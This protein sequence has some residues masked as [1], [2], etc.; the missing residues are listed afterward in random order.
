MAK[1]KGWYLARIREGL[2][3]AVQ[4]KVDDRLNRQFTIG[5]RLAFLTHGS[6]DICGGQF[7]RSLLSIGSVVTQD[8]TSPHVAGLNGTWVRFGPLILSPRRGLSFKVS[9]RSLAP[10]NILQRAAR[11]RGKEF[12]RDGTPS[13]GW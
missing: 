5:D 7:H 4:G 13:Q 10:G 8:A 12:L 3:S 1:L 6:F 11:R 9:T 2:A